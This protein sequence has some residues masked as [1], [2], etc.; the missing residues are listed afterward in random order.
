[1]FSVPMQ[2]Q[3]PPFISVTYPLKEIAK[4]KRILKRDT[5]LQI[6]IPIVAVPGTLLTIVKLLRKAHI[7]QSSMAAKTITQITLTLTPNPLKIPVIKFL[8]QTMNLAATRQ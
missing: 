3:T 5:F 7:L 1:M 8:T 6:I 2:M 4:T